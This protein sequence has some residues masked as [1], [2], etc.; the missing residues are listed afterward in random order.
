MS[1]P[2]PTV[3]LASVAINQSGVV[4]FANVGISAGGVSANPGVVQ[5][6]G[7]VLIFNESGSG[8]MITFNT[9]QSGFY[10]PAGAW[11]PI[12][13]KAGE[14]GYQWTVI[15]NLPNPPVTLLLTTYYYPGEPIPSQPTLGNSP[16]GIGGSITTS[17]VQ[18]L[19]D[20]NRAT[21]AR[22]IDIGNTTIANLIVIHND[23]SFNFNILIGGVAH[24]LLLGQNAFHSLV[25]GNA[26]DVVEVA[27]QLSVDG[28]LVVAGTAGLTYFI[29]SV[30]VATAISI[31]SGSTT[32]VTCGGV[33]A[34][35]SNAVGVEIAYDFAPGAVNCF[36]AFTPSGTAWSAANYP[37]SIL[38]TGATPNI[39]GSC[40]VPL[41]GGK[42][43]V[44]AFNANITGMDIQVFAYIL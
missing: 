43:D 27:N 11:Q 2:L 8:L 7:T 12:P 39:A 20:E 33:G 15:Y 10:L 31:T 19:S 44:K 14:T 28:N 29:S 36:A 30:H 38:A 1:I 32:T 23:G 6:A 4:S 24:Q 16:I 26:T 17:S 18:T 5:N 22:T 42:I 13:I 35:P 41:S 37:A 21:I 25:L 3:S 34:I 9:S 40:K